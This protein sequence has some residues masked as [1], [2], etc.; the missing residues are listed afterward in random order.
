MLKIVASETK[1]AQFQGWSQQVD[2]QSPST[3]SSTGGKKPD[4]CFLATLLITKNNVKFVWTFW[5][6]LNDIESDR[7]FKEQ[8]RCWNVIVK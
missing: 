2:N 6:R 7:I 8:L 1:G 5:N 4:D 3:P